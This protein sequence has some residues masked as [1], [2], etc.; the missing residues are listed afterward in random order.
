MKTIEDY[1]GEVYQLLPVGV[2]LDGELCKRAHTEGNSPIE[3]AHAHTNGEVKI[4]V[5]GPEP[6]AEPV[7]VHVCC[8]RFNHGKPPLLPNT[9]EQAKA[10]SRGRRKVR[11]GRNHVLFK[12][13]NGYCLLGKV[14]GKIAVL[15]VWL[16]PS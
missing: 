12:E 6:V 13:R 3:A 1:I 14:K 5:T 11:L 2:A 7:E 4:E 16:D 15:N 8:I 10:W 9:Y